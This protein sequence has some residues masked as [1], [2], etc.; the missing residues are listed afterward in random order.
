MV[1]SQQNA[2]NI[3]LLR[4]EGHTDSD[5]D[6]AANQVLSEHRAQAVVDYLVSHG[7]DRGRLRPVGC[8]SRD[9]LFPN[10]TA[11]HKALNRRTEFDIE[12]I[13]GARPEGYTEPCAPNPEQKHYN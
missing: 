13:N 4:V 8:A 3:T 1:G 7:V 6:P 11:E 10:D 2:K 12:M 9:P 5:G